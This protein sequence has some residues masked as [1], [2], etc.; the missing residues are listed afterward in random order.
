M[1]NREHLGRWKTPEAEQRFRALEDELWREHWPQPPAALDVDT[2]LGP[3]RV[4][5]WDGEPAGLGDPV[6]FLHG[7]GATSLMWTGV[8]GPVGGVAYAVDTIGDVGRS[9]QEAPTEDAADLAAWLDEA[10]AGAGVERAHLVGASYGGFLALNQAIRRPDRVASVALVEPGG[11][12]PLQFG[13]F[14][15]WGIAVMVASA[16]PGS[17]RSSAASVLRMPLLDDRRA[18]RMARLGYSTHRPRLVPPDPFSDEQLRSV[19]VPV[20]LLLAE[21]SQVHDAAAALARAT[22]LLPDVDAEMIPGAGHALPV[23]HSEEVTARLAG[24]LRRVD[25]A[26]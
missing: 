2:H 17:L 10:L 5:R 24:F 25:T 22:A 7:T 21:R 11:I 16:L 23:S 26:P 19:S 6:V 3:T 4:Y 12:V 20:L 1:K 15:A 8:V 9:R 13:R 18:M 14:M